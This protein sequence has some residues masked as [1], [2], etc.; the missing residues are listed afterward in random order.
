MRETLDNMSFKLGIKEEAN[1]DITAA[2][3]YYE[4]KRIGL[5][6]EFLSHLEIYFKRILENPKHFPHKRKPFRE[7]FVKRFPF[8]VV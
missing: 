6:E 3:L 2:Y 7:A 1:E 4:N 8:M 5:G